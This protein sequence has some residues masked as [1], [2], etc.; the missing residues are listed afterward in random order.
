MQGES[1]DKWSTTEF[2]MFKGGSLWKPPPM[3][4]YTSGMPED[5]VEQDEET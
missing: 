2:R 1:K 3:N 5:L 4:L